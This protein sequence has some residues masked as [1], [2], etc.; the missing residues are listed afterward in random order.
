MYVIRF[1]S[2]RTMAL[3]LAVVAALAVAIG[4]WL[5]PVRGVE[6]STECSVLVMEGV[7]CP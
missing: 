5:S 4:W 3:A 1:R 2:R 6:H 7:P